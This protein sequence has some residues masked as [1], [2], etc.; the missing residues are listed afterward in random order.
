MAREHP[1][2]A[3]I[4]VCTNRPT[5]ARI[6]L[7]HLDAQD[8]DFH[9]YVV[10]NSSNAAYCCGLVDYCSHLQ[11]GVTLIRLWSMT[12]QIGLAY[13]CG[14]WHALVGG[15]TTHYVKI[16]D[17]VAI[18]PNAIGEL[19]RGCDER[20]DTAVSVLLPYSHNTGHYQYRTMD[21]QRLHG[22]HKFLYGACF[23][24][25]ASVFGRIGFFTE[26]A[27][28]GMDL[29]FGVRA[30]SAG[31]KIINHP[32]LRA[33]HLG[34]MNGT[35]VTPEGKKSRKYCT[36][37]EVQVRTTIWDRAEVRQALIAQVFGDTSRT[38]VERAQNPLDSTPVM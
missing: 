29:D 4:T 18:K 12:T 11:H 2:T 28:R 22:T 1:E 5:Y 3:V 25:P 33:L 19:R 31:F 14:L 21:A 24:V 23:M 15:Y 10:L 30:Q 16:D 35:E 26:E 13:N 34:T 37:G 7:D 38:Q 27:Q 17:D 6:M 9:I 32:S 20:Y 8:T 36:F